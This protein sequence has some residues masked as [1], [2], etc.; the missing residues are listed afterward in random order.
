[1]SRSFEYANLYVEKY[2]NKNL[3]LDFTDASEFIYFA[4]NGY[5][6]NAKL[7]R[8]EPTMLYFRNMKHLDLAEGDII[9]VSMRQLIR[10]KEYAE[11]VSSNNNQDNEVPYNRFMSFTSGGWLEE[12]FHTGEAFKNNRKKRRLVESF[13]GTWQHGKPCTLEG[14]SDEIDVEVVDVGQGSTNLIQS[15]KELTIFDFGSSIFAKKSEME[16]IAKTITDRFENS[17][18]PSLIISHWDCD[19]YNL[20][21]VLDDDMLSK[22]CCVFFPAE[23]ISLTAKQVVKRLFDKCRYICTIKSPLSKGNEEVYPIMSN[24]NYTLYIGKKTASI[25]KSGLALA[26]K[27]SEDITIFGADHTN[28]QVWDCIYPDV[29]SNC[30]YERFNVVVPHHGGKCGKINI[31]NYDPKFGIAAISVG[32]NAYKHPNQV[33]IDHY[34]KM[35]FEVKRTDWERKN[36]LIKMK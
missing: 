15:H 11:P 12:L 30:T 23:V 14:L 7:E 5:I 32:K 2:D 13:E 17:Y 18:R 27:S 24:T 22:F 25:N 36:I 9:A 33:T 26:I 8:Y 31:S 10:H 28:K 35:G 20:L 21:T 1:M 29:I 4:Y 6:E 19:H 16:R 3:I 34:E